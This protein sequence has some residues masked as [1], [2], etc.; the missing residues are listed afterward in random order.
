M[1]IWKSEDN[2]WDSSLL[3]VHGPG[4][5][6]WVLRHSISLV[7]FW[8]S[9][10]LT[11]FCPSLAFIAN[12]H[13]LFSVSALNVLVTCHI[14]LSCHLSYNFV[15]SLEIVYENHSPEQC[16]LLQG[17]APFSVWEDS[18][19]DHLHQ[20]GTTPSWVWL[21]F[22]LGPVYHGWHTPCMQPSVQEAETHTDRAVAQSSSYV[23]KC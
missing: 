6:T 1:N 22:Y 9:S 4:D 17:G 14:F 10:S 2:M 21:E 3:S 13:L 8:N 5:Q 15:L 7:L 12:G 18:S 11:H 19:S 20:A 23:S 16:C